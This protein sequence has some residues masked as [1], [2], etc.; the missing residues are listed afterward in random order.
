MT[1]VWILIVGRVGAD[2]AKQCQCVFLEHSRCIR[3]ANGMGQ[4]VGPPRGLGREKGED[5]RVTAW[6]RDVVLLQTILRNTD[7]AVSLKTRPDW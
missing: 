6:G 1:L 4:S 7:G 5:V 3:E 2:H